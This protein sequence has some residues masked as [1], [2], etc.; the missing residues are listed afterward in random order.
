[1]HQNICVGDVMTR[2]FISVK[3]DT[4]L[5]KCAKTMIK[6]R[7][8]SLILVENKKLKGILTERDILWAL[9]KK[10]KKDLKDI[11]AKDIAVRKIKTVKPSTSLEEAINR[12]TKLKIR[13]F[14]VIDN[15]NVVG[16]LT[17]KDVLRFAP[18]LWESVHD[19]MKIREETEKLKR[20]DSIIKNQGVKQEYCEECGN[21]DLLYKID[22]RFLC[23]AC[24]DMM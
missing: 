19:I 22:G 10:S 8:G 11:K 6:K 16:M 14:P 20:R 21:F 1:M 9:I 7:V 2:K 24:R 18:T 23:K 4:N 17:L 15:K 3:P 5:L 13:W 12:M